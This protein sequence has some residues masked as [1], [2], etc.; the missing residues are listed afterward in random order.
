MTFKA[1]QHI[2]HP[3]FGGGVVTRILEP[4]PLMMIDFGGELGEKMFS[5]PVLAR[6]LNGGT[7]PTEPRRPRQA[8]PAPPKPEAAAP[9]PRRAMR[10]GKKQ[11]AFVSTHTSDAI[12]REACEMRAAGDTTAIGAAAWALCWPRA[13]V[14]ARAREL[15]IV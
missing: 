1:G 9:K 11:W 8:A 2:Q 10:Q 14:R 4:S 12:I 13:A 5:I 6:V 15:G 7:D 3:K